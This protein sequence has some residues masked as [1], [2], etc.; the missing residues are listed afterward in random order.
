MSSDDELRMRFHQMRARMTPD[1]ALLGRLDVALAATPPGESAPASSPGSL[2]LR[3]VFGVGLLGGLLVG[4]TVTALLVT[5]LGPASGMPRGWVPVTVSTPTAEPVGPSVAAT[6]AAYADIY[7]IVAALARTNPSGGVT[8][9]LAPA[10]GTA[11][12]AGAPVPAATK[13]RDVSGYSGTNVQVAGIDEGDIVKTDGAHLYIARGRTVA[14]VATAGAATHQVA[15]ID[16][17]GLSTGSEILTGPVT[18]LMIVG[19]TLVVLTHGF[20]ADVAGWSAASAAYISLSA[21]H[22]KAAFF[23]ISDPAHPTYLSQ[24]EQS[25]SYVDS[26]LSDGVLYLVSSYWVNTPGID[27]ANPGTFVPT[28]RDGGGAVTVAPGDVALP[29]GASEPAYSVVTAVDVARRAVVGDQAVLGYMPT[30]YMSESNL[31]LAATRWPYA[32]PAT[33][34]TPA[35]VSLGGGT[36]DGTTTDIVRIALVGGAV[37]LAA[38]GSVAGSVVDQFALDERDGYL[39]LATTWNDSAGSYQPNA[40]LWVLDPALKVVGSIPRLSK[41]EAVQSVRFDGT[42]GYVV[43]FRTMDPLFTIDLRDPTAPTVQGALKIPGF[44]QYLHPFG[45]GLLLGVGVEADTGTGQ[46]TGLKVALFDVHDPFDVQV[47]AST[48]VPGD[49][50]PVGTDHKAA[51]VDVERGLV[52]F[53]T[54]TWLNA[55]TPNS[56]GYYDTTATD[57]YHVYRWDGAQF[58]EQA[59]ITLTD[60][61]DDAA[62][63]RGVR[64][65]SDF[66]IAEPDRVGV[67][68]M[69]RYARLADVRLS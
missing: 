37:T 26:R 31:Y 42:V 16:V 15:T 10:S 14:V 41:D 17:S 47:R 68:D 24:V 53:V 35:P 48:A 56:Y 27:P 46:P 40:A 32:V 44:S 63:I 28:V 50:T 52:G 59:A 58:A 7:S 38:Q 21:S 49:S 11:E 39:R 66:Y 13:G 30:V 8:F 67:Y 3:G 36:T 34:A 2:P 69:D 65:G 4:A 54:T 29:P 18:D 51:F 5:G 9:G 33:A 55:A 43:T 12:A 23:D 22:L 60:V 64:V 1:E 20:D 45:D 19:T 61:P 25:G 57:V 6:P 62:S